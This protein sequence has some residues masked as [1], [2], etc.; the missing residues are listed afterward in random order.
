M[1]YTAT[2]LSARMKG[3]V[4]EANVRPLRRRYENTTHIIPCEMSGRNPL[5]AQDFFRN[6]TAIQNKK[7]Y[8]GA[9]PSL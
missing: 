8:A 1:N 9:Y 4:C 3:H 2:K 7:G 6:G 5:S